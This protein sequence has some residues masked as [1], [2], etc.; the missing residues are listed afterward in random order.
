MHAIVEN[1]SVTSLM[2]VFNWV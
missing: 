1:V 2:S